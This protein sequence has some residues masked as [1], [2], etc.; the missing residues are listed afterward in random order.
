MVLFMKI[1]LA[2]PPEYSSMAAATGL[3]PAFMS[4]SYVNGRLR[5][6]PYRRSGRGGVMHINL[7][8]QMKSSAPDEIMR[9]LDSRDLN[10]VALDT[11]NECGSEATARLA[12]M[13]DASGRTLYLPCERGVPE[14]AVSLVCT[15]ISGGSLEA[16]LREAVKLRGAER[17]ALETELLRMDFSLPCPSGEGQVPEPARFKKLLDGASVFFSEELCTNYFSYTEAGKV[18]FVLFDNAHSIRRKLSL[19]ESLDIST[20]FLYYPDVRHILGDIIR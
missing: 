14:C 2:T 1:I 19:A 12:S 6:A 10:G 17:I 11:A 18:H 15:G 4:Y 8:G 13:L 5:S 7:A 9:E 16:M 20:A 3:D